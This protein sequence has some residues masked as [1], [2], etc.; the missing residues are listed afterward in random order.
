[1]NGG[2]PDEQR[3]VLVVDDVAENLMVL[4]HIL[5]DEFRV[6]AAR[7]PERALE[8]VFGDEPPDLV[9]LDVMMPG[10]DGFEVCQRLKADPR[11]RHIPV[12][13]VTA[14]GEVADEKHGFEVGGVDYVLK[15]VSPPVVLARVR[16][17]LA[18]YDRNRELERR[19]RARTAELAETR[20]EIIRRLGRAAEFKDN[21]TGLH[22]IRMSHYSRLIGEAA[23]MDADEAEVLLNAAPMHDVGKIGIPDRILSK[24]APLTKAEWKLM[25]RHPEM[26]AE[27]IGVHDSDV[28][29]MAREIAL[30]HH[31]RWDG[32]GYPAALAGEAIPFTGRVVALADVFD[33]LTTRRPY[34]EAW[35][36]ED[37]ML[38]IREMSGVQFDPGLVPAM[39]RALP[40]IVELSR[41]Y[42]EDGSRATNLM[43]A[44]DA[45]D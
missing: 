1:M 41:E 44:G 28:L 16:T 29:R 7:G 22:V 37:S 33:A 34:K 10:M 40:E 32:S 27:I 2:R 23:G 36:I 45:A 25:R 6:L 42:A 5:R 12:I 17:H 15:P 9:L 8:I 35:S 20:L 26:G 39:E 31:E 18:L 43:P 4:D 3:V 38:Y 21:Q 14:R 24:R 13:F 19:V 30:T 11:T